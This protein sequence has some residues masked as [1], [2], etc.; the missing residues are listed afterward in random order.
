MDFI[1][2]RQSSG[3]KGTEG[4]DKGWFGINGYGRLQIL[5]DFAKE[6]NFDESAKVKTD[7]IPPIHWN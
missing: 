3:Q 2:R 4:K 7:Y 1:C 5:F 6:I